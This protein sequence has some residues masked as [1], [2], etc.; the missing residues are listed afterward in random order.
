MKITDPRPENQGNPFT[1]SSY[2]VISTHEEDENNHLFILSII[3]TDE[4][5]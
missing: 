4:P 5:E 1:I 2:D 3:H